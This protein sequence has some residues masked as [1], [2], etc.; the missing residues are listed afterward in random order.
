MY[1]VTKNGLWSSEASGSKVEKP[2]RFPK[3]PR[4]AHLN[5]D[6]VSE[7]EGLK[8]IVTEKLDGGQLSFNYEKKDGE[9]KLVDIRTHNHTPIDPNSK[10]NG[11]KT[12]ASA[13]EEAKSDHLEWLSRQTVATSNMARIYT[14]FMHP[15]A[16]DLLRSVSSAKPNERYPSN[17]LNKFHAFEAWYNI[18]NPGGDL[19]VRKLR[20]G[21]ADFTLEK[22]VP[23]MD[24]GLFN[25][26]FLT[27]LCS[28]LQE[29]YRCQVGL[30]LYF[31][32]LTKGFM[33]L[34][35]ATYDGDCKDPISLLYDCDQ[36]S[37]W[38]LI[39]NM[40]AR[41]MPCHGEI[42]MREAVLRVVKE[43]VQQDGLMGTYLKIQKQRQLDAYSQ[44]ELTF[45]NEIKLLQL[46][47]LAIMRA[48]SYMMA[49]GLFCDRKKQ[50]GCV[51]TTQCKIILARLS[52]VA[53]FKE[54]SYF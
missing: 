44:P 22:S 51:L 6:N 35:G 31:P 30:V 53:I 18:K 15:K 36:N 28:H 29:N 39:N 42:P 11:C 40:R 48:S 10:F 23:L 20:R 26:E 7:L 24:E 47:K 5:A 3:R 43:V 4:D 49:N 41:T 19:T 13:V 45:C 21:D 37:N 34:T 54:S 12:F 9:W 27:K 14:E 8:C 16:G 50:S 2:R 17:M 33:L 52:C 38:A 25:L 32:R 46:T 1:K